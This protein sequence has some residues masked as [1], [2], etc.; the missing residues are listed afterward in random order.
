[1]DKVT[2]VIARGG[3]QDLKEQGQGRLNRISPAFS[4]TLPASPSLTQKAFAAHL[5]MHLE[6][7]HPS[8]SLFVHLFYILQT[9][10]DLM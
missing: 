6:T 1:M 5:A 3:K 10:E 8:R 9:F 2:L 7:T 4:G